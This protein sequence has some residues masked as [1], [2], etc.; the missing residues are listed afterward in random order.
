MFIISIISN[1][2]G[3][4]NGMEIVSE[5]YDDS[6]SVAKIGCELF[7]TIFN[8]KINE[9]EYESD[10]LKPLI[11]IKLLSNKINSFEKWDDELC[12]RTFMDEFNDIALKELWDDC[13]TEYQIF[14]RSLMKQ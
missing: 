3:A 5:Y 4:M 2:P 7:L 9:R 14:F 10:K 11:A 8:E 1:D 6:P 12:V 13:D